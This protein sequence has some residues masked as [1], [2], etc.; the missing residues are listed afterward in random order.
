MVLSYMKQQIIL[1]RLCK[2]YF[3]CEYRFRMADGKKKTFYKKY[4]INTIICVLMLKLTFLV[5]ISQMHYEHQNNSK[6]SKFLI[7]VNFRNVNFSKRLHY[8]FFFQHFTF[9]KESNL[10]IEGAQRTIRLAVSA[11]NRVTA[12]INYLREKVCFLCLFWSLCHMN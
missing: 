11:S 4:F 1:R 7:F 2:L 5:I 10:D 12:D 6:K 8:V 9:C 3:I